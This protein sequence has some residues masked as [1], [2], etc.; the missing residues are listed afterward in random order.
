MILLKRFTYE[1]EELYKETNQDFYR[2][3]FSTAGIKFLFKTDSESLFLKLKTLIST[4]RKYFSVDV[5][6]NGTPVDYI[7]NFSNFE[8]PQN[9]AQMEFSLG[10]LKKLNWVKAKKPYVFICLGLLKH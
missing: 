10:N 3:T 8:L 1:Q 5:L 6:V 4:T 7:D 2:R 9:Y